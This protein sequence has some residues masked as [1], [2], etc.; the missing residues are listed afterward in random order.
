MIHPEWRG[1]ELQVAN[2]IVDGLAGVGTK[3]YKLYHLR[4]RMTIPFSSLDLL[5]IQPLDLRG[6]TCATKTTRRF[7]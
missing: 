2:N 1:D 4:K 6:H 3:V 5:E 7:A